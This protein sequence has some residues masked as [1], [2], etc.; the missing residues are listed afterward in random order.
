METLLAL[1]VKVI[2]KRPINK[3]FP[4]IF[5]AQTPRLGFVSLSAALTL[6]ACERLC[7]RRGWR[8]EGAGQTG[9]ACKPMLQSSAKKN[10]PRSFLLSF[11]LM[12]GS[13]EGSFVVRTRNLHFRAVVS[14]GFFE[15]SPVD[16]SLFSRFI[17]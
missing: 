8:R 2:S 13:E 12:S 16:F 10:R 14:T 17:V 15:L 5:A 1:A 11:F 7:G 3:E 6:V 4:R 9:D